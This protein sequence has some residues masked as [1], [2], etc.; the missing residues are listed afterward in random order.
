M[1]YM[2]KPDFRGLGAVAEAT[3]VWLF[4]GSEMGAGR[5]SLM[6]AHQRRGQVERAIGPD[7]RGPSP[8]RGS[9]GVVV[10]AH[11][12]RSVLRVLPLGAV[13]EQHLVGDD[14]VGGALDALLVRELR[15]ADGP[16][17]LTSEPFFRSF[18]EV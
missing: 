2:P 16:R 10:P 9:E 6:A 4:L 1:M 7:S 18:A 13:Q 15:R 5:I 3:G 8:G 14:L 12:R 11:R 17:R